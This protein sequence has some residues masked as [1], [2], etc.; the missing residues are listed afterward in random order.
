MSDRGVWLGGCLLLLALV[1]GI[2]IGVTVMSPIHKREVDLIQDQLDEAIIARAEAVAELEANR[3]TV[4]AWDALTSWYDEESSG[5]IQANGRP[6]DEDRLTAA[7]RSLPFNTILILENIETGYLAPVRIEDRGP[8]GWTG[9]S[10]DVS[11]AVAQRLGI[12]E[13]GVAKIRCYML[14]EG[15]PSKEDWP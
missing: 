6:F 8:A 1:F 4:I 10:L 2:V 5:G 12:V 3:K 14:T 15:R 13:R 9:R 7:H 11:R